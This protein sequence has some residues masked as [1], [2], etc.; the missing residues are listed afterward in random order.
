MS[1]NNETTDHQAR[2]KAIVGR[3]AD[4]RKASEAIEH[5]QTVAQDGAALCEF[6]AWFGSCAHG[7]R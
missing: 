1:D 4:S 7:P 5:A 3:I 6:F 2:P